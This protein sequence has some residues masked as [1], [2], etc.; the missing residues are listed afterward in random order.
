MGKWAAGVCNDFEGHGAL[1]PR[2]ARVALT[3]GFGAGV[4]VDPVA[5][6]QRQG[7]NP[8]GVLF[9]FLCHPDSDPPACFSLSLA[10]SGHSHCGHGFRELSGPEG[11]RRAGRSL[12]AGEQD[13]FLAGRGRPSQMSARRVARGCKVTRA[14]SWESWVQGPVLARPLA[15]GGLAAFFLWAKA[16]PAGI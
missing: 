14:Q 11:E 1:G 6:D 9:V 4:W 5:P 12:G 13:V 8:Q 3:P 15:L 7:R 16:A 2:V 10:C